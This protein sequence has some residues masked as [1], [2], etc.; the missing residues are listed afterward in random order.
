[1]PIL[2]NRKGVAKV[3]NKGRNEDGDRRSNVEV[4]VAEEL[5]YDQRRGSRDSLKRGPSPKR[6]AQ[7]FQQSV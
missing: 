1:M 2:A 7:V 6:E 4:T 3:L 5:A